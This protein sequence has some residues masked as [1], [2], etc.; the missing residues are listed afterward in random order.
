MDV[1]LHTDLVS[2]ALW[3]LQKKKPLYIMPQAH[4]LDPPLKPEEVSA[5]VHPDPKIVPP[6]QPRWITALRTLPYSDVIFSG[7][8][9]GTVKLWKLSEDKR[10]IQPVGTL[11]EPSSRD[12][13]EFNGVS[14]ESDDL[15]SNGALPENKPWVVRG[16]INDISVFERGDRGKDG[17]CVVAA[18]GKD[19]RLGKWKKVQG[20]RNGAVVFEVPRLGKQALTNGHADQLA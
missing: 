17:L 2:S 5:E 9:D 4:G 1:A 20:G 14:E 6:P 3:S 8:W 19:H 7:S 11:C 15:K 10:S 16:V 18:L 13:P 12:S